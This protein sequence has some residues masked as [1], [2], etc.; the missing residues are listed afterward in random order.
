MASDAWKARAAPWN[1][2]W[3]LGG[4]PSSRV[5]RS[6][7]VTAAPSETLGA[8]LNETVTAGNWPWWL[9]ASVV[10]RCSI[11]ARVESGTWPPPDERR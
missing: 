11:V 6:I 4:M 2:V 7:E 10:A 5:T 3:M 8:R 9:T 1:P